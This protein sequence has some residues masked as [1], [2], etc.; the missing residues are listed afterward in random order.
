MTHPSD[1]GAPFRDELLLP[2]WLDNAAVTIGDPPPLPHWL[3]GAES[4]EETLPD[5]PT[6]FPA[7]PRPTPPP[8]VAVPPTTRVATFRAVKAP[9][10]VA[11]AVSS[12]AL[13]PERS[14]LDELRALR[15]SAVLHGASRRIVAV[16]LAAAL[17][18]AV[19]SA[20]PPIE[21]L[22][23]AD[24]VRV[25]SSVDRLRLGA[26]VLIVL[27]YP[28]ERAGEFAATEETVI[29]HAAARGAT[30]VSVSPRPELT[31]RVR[32]IAP[33]A[34]V[35]ELPP[36]SADPES[37]RRLGQR[38]RLSGTPADPALRFAAGNRPLELAIIIGEQNE[39]ARWLSN[40]RSGANPPGIAVVPGESAALSALRA[41]GQL[42][43]SL[44]TERDLRGYSLLAGQGV[45]PFRS[46]LLTAGPVLAAA[47]VIAA[48]AGLRLRRQSQPVGEA[49]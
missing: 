45:P 17:A 46:G 12:P 29:R 25:Y 30:L 47:L 4:V 16:G 2:D 15:T 21:E 48:T 13:H 19:L 1:R 39:V 28:P 23:T 20:P 35:S 49:Q 36:I 27:D 42:T 43:G 34:T 22:P 9:R 14:R 32:A 18:V 6:P 8:S 38:D 31:G 10:A 3:D 24:V 40:L 33:S 11:E 41:S 37:I 44:R 7:T 26:P 5:L